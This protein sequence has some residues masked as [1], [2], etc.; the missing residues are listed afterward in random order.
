[1]RKLFLENSPIAYVMDDTQQKEWV[2]FIHAAFVDH[3]MFQ[4]QIKYFSGKY[5]VI[6]VDILGHGDSLHAKKG[7]TIDQMSLWI[8]QIMEKHQIFAAHFVG[9]SLGAIIIQDFACRYENKV[10]S[11]ACFGGYDIFHF[12]KEKQKKNSKSQMK[13]MMKALFSIRW[14]A[15]DNKK[16]SAYS[17]KGQEIFYQLNLQFK[18]SSFRYFTKLGNIGRCEEKE[19]TY[20]LLIGCGEYDIPMEIEIIHE[21]GKR[22]NCESVIFPLA[23]HC[24][25]LDV[26]EEFCAYLEKFWAK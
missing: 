22:E 3:R 13:M 2:I 20:P 9:V 23:G 21:W 17:K 7:D 4:E 6:A 25:N 16:I 14:F 12:D 10:S 1:M 24:V 19:R 8:A 26:P 11:L 5:N 18:K 15:K